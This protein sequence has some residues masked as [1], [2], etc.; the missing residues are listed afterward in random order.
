MIRV[1]MNICK[2]SCCWCRLLVILTVCF[3]FITHSVYNSFCHCAFYSENT[4][5]FYLIECVTNDFN[6]HLIQVLLR[7]TVLEEGS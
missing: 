7:Y 6:V 1:E 4:F 3:I 5:V 2:K